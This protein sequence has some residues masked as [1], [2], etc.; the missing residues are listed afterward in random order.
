MIFLGLALYAEGP[1]D[2]RFLCPLLRRLSEDVCLRNAS[3]TVEI[4]EV[5]A[6]DHPASAKEQRR[7]DRILA[8]AQAASGAWDVL[9]VHSD[10][11]GDADRARSTQ[12]EPALA[13]VVEAFGDRGFGIAVVPVRETEAWAIVDGDTLRRVWGTVLADKELGLPNAAFEV[14]R[15]A[16]PKATLKKAFEA[17]HPHRRRKSG[18]ASAH[19]SEL[20]EQ[21]ALDKLRTL[22]AF[23]RLEADLCGA[24]R[25]LQILR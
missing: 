23:A 14:E 24:L 15:T 12:V 11:S 16:D 4:S 5:L 6:L 8:A 9:F 18:T 20:G 3:G 17:T 10:G 2:Y 21:V 19:L 7:E 25:Q 1:T 22:R 13:K